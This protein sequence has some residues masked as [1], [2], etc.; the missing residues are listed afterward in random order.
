MSNCYTRCCFALYITS[1]ECS[2]LR[3][4]IALAEFLETHPDT[5]TIAEHWLSLSA[6]FRSDFQPTG[7]EVFSGFLAIFSDSD[8]PTFGTDFAFEV[9]DD[10]MIRVFASADQFEPDAVAGLL[11]R[12]ITQSL[13]VA[14][15]WSYDSDR[16]QPDAFGCGGFLIDSAGIHWIATSVV[17]DTTYFAPK[18]VIAIRT[19]DEGLLFWNAK[20]GF[21]SLEAADVFTESQACGTDLPLAGDQPEWLIL[22]ACLWA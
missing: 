15:T 6:R 19:R 13:P 2:L 7:E 12:I 17:Q 16:Y 18:Q 4:A 10:G 5:Q 14:V 9:Q 1:A 21:G 8:F 22:P 11:H 20:S 3:E